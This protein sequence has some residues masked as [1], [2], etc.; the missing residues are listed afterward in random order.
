MKTLVAL[1]GIG[2]MGFGASLV[3]GESALLVAMAAQVALVVTV[4]CVRR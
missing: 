3:F 4:L 1:A 2:I